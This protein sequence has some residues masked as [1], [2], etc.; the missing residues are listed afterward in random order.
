MV[1]EVSILKVQLVTVLLEQFV[2]LPVKIKKKFMMQLISYLSQ[3]DQVKETVVR[4]V[5]E[6]EFILE[7]LKSIL[8]MF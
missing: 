6:M 1:E 3:L 7:L 2:M 8:K 5:L 4:V